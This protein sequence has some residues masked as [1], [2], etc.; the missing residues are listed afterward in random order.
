MAMSLEDRIAETM[1][2]WALGIIL[3]MNYAVE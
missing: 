1:E 3:T 2:T